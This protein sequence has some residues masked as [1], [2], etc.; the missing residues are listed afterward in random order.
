MSRSTW[1]HFWLGL[2]WLLCPVS[3]RPYVVHDGYK[4]A[5]LDAADPAE[6]GV[7]GCQTDTGDSS[8]TKISLPL[9]DWWQLASEPDAGV[10]EHVIGAY[11]WGTH[12]LVVATGSSYFTANAYRWSYVPGGQDRGG[13]LA[14]DGG[15]YRTTHCAA[16]ILIYQACWGCG[17]SGKKVPRRF[18]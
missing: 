14:E 16:R 8:G 15:Q 4:Y 7:L 17:E 6:S 12:V 18:V 10:R 13:R 9:P 1:S 2:A 11:L 3:A 5:T